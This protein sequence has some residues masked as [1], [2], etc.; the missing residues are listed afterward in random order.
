MADWNKLQAGARGNW[1]VT[2]KCMHTLRWRYNHYEWLQAPDYIF[3][4]N[5]ASL[6][7]FRKQMF[8]W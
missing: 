2:L 6:L 8:T 3:V 4:L 1:K 7:P 5:A